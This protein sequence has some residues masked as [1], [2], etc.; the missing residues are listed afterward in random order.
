MATAYTGTVIGA[1]GSPLG[2]RK[3]FYYT[4]SDVAGEY[5]LSPGGG[6]DLVLN[7]VADVYIVE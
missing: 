2:P 1:L 7:G 5:W 4:S 6:S 3:I